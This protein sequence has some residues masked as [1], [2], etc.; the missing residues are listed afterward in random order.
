MT[1]AEAITA[2]YLR[3]TGKTTTPSASKTSKIVGLLNYYQRAWANE[4]GIDWSSLYDPS[5]SIGTVTATDSF[6]LDT[7]SIRKLSDREGDVVRIVWDDGDTETHYSIVPADTLRDYYYGV[8]KENPK[9]HYCARIGDQLVFNH[10]FTST[11]NEFGGEIF[12]PC[13]AYPDEITSTNTSDNDVQVDDPNWLVCATAAEYVR[14]D[15]TRQ[16]QYPNLL[17]EANSIMSRM[18]DDNDNTQITRVNTPWTPGTGSEEVW[19]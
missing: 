6:D 8:D 12:V 19:S 13:Y 18:K 15:I 16:G 4:P 5:L 11:D 9:G 1:I 3:A 17:A 2:T 10:E 14:T 7:T